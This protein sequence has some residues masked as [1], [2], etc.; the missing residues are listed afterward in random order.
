MCGTY[1][2]NRTFSNCVISCSHNLDKGP[3]FTLTSSPVWRVTAVIK[4]YLCCVNGHCLCSPWNLV[5][6]L[7]KMNLH[8]NVG[9]VT[10]VPSFWHGLNFCKPLLRSCRKPFLFTY[11]SH[12]PQ[13]LHQPWISNHL[14]FLGQNCFCH[15]TEK[16]Q[17]WNS[18]KL[19][20][21]PHVWQL[22][23][24]SCFI[25]LLKLYIRSQKHTSHLY[26]K[27]SKLLVL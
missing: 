15:K 17:L 24:T 26:H 25:F 12:W 8:L 3:N 14:S 20:V 2:G 23:N 13:L 9:S 18:C 16:G 11:S 7:M 5:K 6:H 27:V 1:Y 19:L 4:C 10:V 22:P 21:Q